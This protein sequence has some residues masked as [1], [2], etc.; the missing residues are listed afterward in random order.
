MSGKDSICHVTFSRLGLK[1]GPFTRRCRYHRVQDQGQSFT[2]EDLFPRKFCPHAFRI[3]YPYCL[4]LLYDSTYPSTAQS[5]PTRSVKVKCPSSDHFVELNIAIRYSFPFVI[6]KLKNAAIR[7]L[8]FLGID[9]EYPDRDVVLNVSR[10]NKI[11]PLGLTEGQSFFFNIWNRKELC[12]ASFYAAY[13][14]L[15]RQMAI[16]ENS[17][18]CDNSLIHCPDPF[19]VYYDQQSEHSSWDCK[20]FFSITA[21]V[22]EENGHCPHGHRQG[23]SFNLENILPNGF[24]PLAFYSIFPYYLT[25]LHEGRFEWVRKGQFVKVQCPKANGVVMEIELMRQKS[26]GEGAVRV[27]VIENKGVCPKGHSRG[28]TFELDSQNQPLCFH[29]LAGL[30]PLTASNQGMYSCFDTT[31]HLLFKLG[32]L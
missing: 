23:D 31:N 26:L 27:T 6:R 20:D 3:A 13:P 2:G 14:I 25:L 12:P 8:Q 19:G 9:G 16:P 21:E 10:V 24:C 30:I 15:M 17:S 22:I 32:P 29:A 7:A 5:N 28:D 18:S 11:C 1:T 4:S